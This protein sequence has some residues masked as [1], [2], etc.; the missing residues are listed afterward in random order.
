MMPGPGFRSLYPLWLA[1]PP[2]RRSRFTLPSPF[3]TLIDRIRMRGH[4]ARCLETQ[5][6]KAKSDRELVAGSRLVI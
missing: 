2:V 4:V 6:A 5:H 1:L 3:Y